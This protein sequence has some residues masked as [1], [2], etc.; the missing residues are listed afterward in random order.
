MHM[1]IS[2]LEQALRTASEQ[3]T[4]AEEGRVLGKLGV[5]WLDQGN[6]AEAAHCFAQQR[7]IQAAINGRQNE[8]ITLDA[9][10]VSALGEGNLEEALRCCERTVQL[11]REIGDRLLTG[12]ALRRLADVQAALGQ[13]VGADQNYAAS[14]LFFDAKEHR[15]EIVRTRWAYGQFLIRQGQRWRG[16][17][18][19]DECVA[20]EQETGDPQ[21]EE[22]AALVEQLWKGGELP[23]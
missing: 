11:A 14:I 4:R 21:A 2:E 5:A 19:L 22:H 15:R 12:L 1:T 10:G 17:R 7:Q 3:G 16:F 18:L 6:V 23:A 13:D 20:Y 8:V 9:Q